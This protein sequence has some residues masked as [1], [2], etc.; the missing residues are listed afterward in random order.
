MQF[1]LSQ[2]F[3]SQFVG[4][5]SLKGGMDPLKTQITLRPVRPIRD[6]E[7]KS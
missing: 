2:D 5:F 7:H 4:K 1:T 3:L 6:R